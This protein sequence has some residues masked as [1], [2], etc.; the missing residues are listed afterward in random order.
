MRQ[1]QWTVI[2]PALEYSSDVEVEY[3]MI[4]LELLSDSER[5]F[6]IRSNKFTSRWTKPEVIEHVIRKPFDEN[7]VWKVACNHY[8]KIMDNYNL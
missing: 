5:K 4:L 6:I 3:P 1:K 8:Q 7:H 2:R